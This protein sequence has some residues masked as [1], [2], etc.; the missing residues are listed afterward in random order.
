VVTDR[1][2]LPRSAHTGEEPRWRDT[3]VIPCE[4]WRT[5]GARSTFGRRQRRDGYKRRA[6]YVEPMRVL[7]HERQGSA[8]V[9]ISENAD[10]LRAH[11]RA[12]AFARRPRRQQRQ[13]G[14]LSAWQSAG[15]LTENGVVEQ[16]LALIGPNHDRPKLRQAVEGR[17]DQGRRLSD[18]GRPDDDHQLR[19]TP[20]SV[21]G[22]GNEVLDLGRRPTKALAVS[23][24]RP[25]DVPVTPIPP[26]RSNALLPVTCPSMVTS[27]W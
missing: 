21:V 5:R 14:D 3:R 10:Q 8:Q 12:S 25:P 11:R 1:L 24:R 26:P 13:A 22:R 2:A 23:P 20:L 7:D 16:R 6:G 15:Q 18:P 27:T 19:A 9:Q 17:R 4:S